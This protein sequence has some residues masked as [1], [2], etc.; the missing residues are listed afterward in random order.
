MIQKACSV[1]RHLKVTAN[2]DSANLFID[3]CLEPADASTIPDLTDLYCCYQLFCT[4][5]G[6]RPLSNKNFKS[7]MSE[8]I[9]HLYLPRRTKPGSGG[10]EKLPATFFGF[11]MVE[12]LWKPEVGFNDVEDPS[13]ITAPARHNSLGCMSKRKLVEGAF[14]KLANH[15]PS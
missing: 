15:Q 14:E 11:Q 10:S 5:Q 4:M 9:R 3:S 2:A 12:G 7:R 1:G 13:V 6:N 8:S